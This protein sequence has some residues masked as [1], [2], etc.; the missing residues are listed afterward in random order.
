M[1]AQIECISRKWQSANIANNH[2]GS[3]IF[4]EIWKRVV[5]L[6]LN[7][8]VHTRIYDALTNITAA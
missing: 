1:L 6:C 3:E 2:K 4:T 7:I 5:G 8:K